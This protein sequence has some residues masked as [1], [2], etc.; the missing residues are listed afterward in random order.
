MT[1]SAIITEKKCRS[2]YNIYIYNLKNKTE[3]EES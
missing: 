2:Y 1:I 3:K